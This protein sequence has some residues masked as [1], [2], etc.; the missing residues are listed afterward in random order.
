MD[1]A[2]DMQ[3]CMAMPLSLLLGARTTEIPEQV[4]PVGQDHSYSQR[5]AVTWVS[6][7]HHRTQ[8][9]RKQQ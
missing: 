8:R 3:L 5:A 4:W 6:K 2:C 1:Q 9:D 7:Q